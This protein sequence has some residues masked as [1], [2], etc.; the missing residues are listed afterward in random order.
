MRVFHPLPCLLSLALVGLSAMGL[1]ADTPVPSILSSNV[2]LYSAQPTLGTATAV[3][4]WDLPIGR[5]TFRMVSGT[6]A[7]LI[8]RSGRTLGFHFT[9]KATF[10]FQSDDPLERTALTS[11][12]KKNLEATN[13]KATLS[14]ADGHQILTEEVKSF[15]LWCA[16]APILLPSGAPAE[17]P[18]AS[19]SRDFTFFGRD[20]LGDRGHDFALNLA[21][22]PTK[23]LWRAE[24][25]GTDSPFIFVLDQGGSQLES[26]WAVADPIRPATYD[27]LRRILLSQQPLGWTW[28]GPLSPLV[29]LTSVDIDMRAGLGGADLKVTETLVAGNAGLAVVSL[30]LYNVVDPAYKLGSYHVSRVLDGQGRPL[31]FHHRHDGIL[32]Q[33]DQPHPTGQRFTLT[34]EYGGPIL[35]RPGGDNYWELGVEPWFPQPDMDGQAYTVHALIRTHKDDIPVACGRTI[36]RESTDKGNLLEVRIDNPVQFF[37]VFAG[38]YSFT[39]E[40]KD[41]LTIRVAAYATHG[42]NMQK[43]LIGIARQTIG[44]YEQI[45]EKFPFEEYNIVQ[46]NSYGYG[47]AP[48]GMMIITNEAF[49]GKVDLI[50]SLFTRGINE[51]FAHEIAHQYWGHL[52]KMPSHEEQ[53]IT[54]SFANYSAA[55]AMRAM[56]NKGDSTYEGMLSRWRNQSSAYTELGTIPFANRLLW[57]NDP[58][59]TFMARTSLLYEKGALILATLH[60]EMGDRQFAL[61]MKSIIANFRWRAATTKSI[62]QIAS[63]AGHKDFDPLFRDCYWGTQMPR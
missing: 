11:N 47:Q 24:I 6:A 32:V 31:P 52:V 43:R 26:L 53:W 13:T 5:M 9:G 4:N 30:D 2:E 45:F 14:E 41:G 58:Q 60:K 27:G 28:K 37:S 42:G 35:L 39:E 44:F 56:K 3:R 49:T 10:R 38:A 29:S 33:L 63:M 40:T 19:F 59:A 21:N 36:R 17:A 23:G 54:E 16:G 62:E 8:S 22:T 34:F 61:F 48:P 50:S 7:P 18:S 1:N 46:V 51:R 15:T 25:I 55:L 20:G 57:I 12:F